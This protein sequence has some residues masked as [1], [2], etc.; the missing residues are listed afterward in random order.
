MRNTTRNSRPL[1]E[2]SVMSDTLAPSSETS[3]AATSAVA[4]RN[5]SRS[6]CSDATF[7]SSARF[8]TRP[9][10]SMAAATAYGDLGLERVPVTGPLEQGLDQPVRRTG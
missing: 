9:S 7:M 4:S 1:A 5:D 2:C 10:A 6:V 8:S 3:V